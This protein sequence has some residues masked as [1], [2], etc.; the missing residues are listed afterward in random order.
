MSKYI[1]TDE[2]VNSTGGS[3]ITEAGT[4]EFKTTNVIHK[5][6]Q[7]D[8]TDLFE[9]TYATKDGATMRKTFFWG[10]LSKPTSEYK[11]RT[12]IFMYLK[13]CGVHIYRDQLDTED[14]AGFY[15]IVKDKKFTAKVDMKPDQNDPNKSWAEIGFSGFVFDQNHVLY[16]EGTSPVA[17]DDQVIENP[18]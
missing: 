12:L 9:C 16:K 13:A 17:D 10:D 4:Y 5:V 18:W 15:E 1:A 3:Y 14:A 7:R 6:N 11:A 2:D 8:G